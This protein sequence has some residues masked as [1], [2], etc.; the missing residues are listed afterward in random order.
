MVAGRRARL[1]AA[2]GELFRLA[3]QAACSP[4]QE[5]GDTAHEDS[6]GDARR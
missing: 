6:A 3:D 4:I 2:S 1:D 5:T